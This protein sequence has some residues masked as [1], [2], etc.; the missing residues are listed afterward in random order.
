MILFEMFDEPA[1]LSLMD[2]LRDFLPMAVEYLDLSS[3]P[4]INLVTNVGQTEHPT[5]G[6]FINDVNVI[7][8]NIENRNP[9]DILR[10]LAHELTHYS[11]GVNGMLDHTS[12][13]TGSAEENEANAVAGIIM[14]N[15]N[16]Q[17]PK[18]LRLA[19]VIIE[20]HL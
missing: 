14:R 12:G 15:F 20:K 1:E 5:F 2:A 16:Q 11:Q 13:D 4:K 18:Y 17:Y 10:T 6:K 19:P 8:V 7:Q 3:L 9:N